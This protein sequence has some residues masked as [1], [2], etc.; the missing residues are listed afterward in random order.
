MLGGDAIRSVNRL[1][2]FL[3]LS[4][5]KKI[6]VFF[7]NLCL[8]GSWSSGSSSW[9]LSRLLS[10]QDLGDDLLLLDQESANDTITNATGR[11]GTTI[12]TVDGLETSGHAGPFSWSGWYDAVKLD[13]AVT[14]LW[15]GGALL[16]VLVGETTAWCLDDLPLVRGGVVRQASSQCKSLNHFFNLSLM[17]QIY[18]NNVTQLPRIKEV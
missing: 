3:F 6:E 11:S 16:D 10:L 14:T 17:R 8:L 13:F 12:G 5:L 4:H 1:A 15:E 7:S 2:C 18:K 9:L